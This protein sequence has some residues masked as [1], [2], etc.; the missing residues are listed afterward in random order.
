[1]ILKQATKEKLFLT[2]PADEIKITKKENDPKAT[3]NKEEVAKLET[4]L[5]H[6]C[7]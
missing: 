7:T 2:N 6:S 5:P 1:M 4:L 3:L